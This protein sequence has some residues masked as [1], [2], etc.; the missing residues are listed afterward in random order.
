MLQYEPEVSVEDLLT[1]KK[2][3]FA[4]QIV[5]SAFLILSVSIN[6]NLAASAGGAASIHTTVS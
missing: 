1:T 4:G 2:G 3:L 5:V 6:A